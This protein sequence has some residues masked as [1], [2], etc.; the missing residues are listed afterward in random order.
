MQCRCTHDCIY[1]HRSHTSDT[2]LR[3][4]PGSDVSAGRWESADEAGRFDILSCRVSRRPLER[5][6]ATSG[7]EWTLHILPAYLP[8]AGAV[9]AEEHESFGT[10]SVDAGVAGHG[11]G[12]RPRI[13]KSERR[14]TGVWIRRRG[15][16]LA[17]LSGAA[18]PS[19][20]CS[21]RPLP[22]TRL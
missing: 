11:L 13:T 1:S 8:V 6:A 19:Q 16:R 5:A 3:V 17:R 9:S 4:P 21:S 15:W 22:L 7:C 2:R 12:L 20:I 10:N 14:V 18:G